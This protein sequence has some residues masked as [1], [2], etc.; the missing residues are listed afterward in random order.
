MKT[1]HNNRS[2]EGGVSNLP[3][4]ALIYSGFQYSPISGS[5]KS[6]CTIPRK[7]I[8]RGGLDPTV[9]GGRAD[10]PLA[11]GYLHA[12]DLQVGISRIFRRTDAEF[13]EGALNALKWHS[14]VNE[15]KIKVKVEDGVVILEGEAG[16]NFQRAA[17][18][19]VVIKSGDYRKALV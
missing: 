18:K 16:W 3:V 17:A 7:A 12:E 2:G 10:G 11:G 5:P 15:D 8:D 9:V 6:P 19:Q 13:A 1:Y 14:T 4:Q